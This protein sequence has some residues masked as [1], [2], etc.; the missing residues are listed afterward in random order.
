LTGFTGSSGSETK[1]LCAHRFRNQHRTIQ[2][3]LTLLIG[4]STCSFSVDRIY[5]IAGMKKFIS[6]LLGGPR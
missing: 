1:K 4:N 6:H 5:R 2:R 3:P